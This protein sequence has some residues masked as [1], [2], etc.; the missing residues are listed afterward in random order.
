[1]ED[2]DGLPRS[3]GGLSFIRDSDNHKTEKPYKWTAALEASKEHL[4]TNISLETRDDIA[5]RDIRSLINSDKLS[6]RE[7][8]FQI[9][10]HPNMD[11]SVKQQDS[12][13]EEY[14]SGLVESIKEATSAEFACCVNFVFRQCTQAMIANPEKI[15]QMAGTS[16]SAKEPE[17]PAFPAHADYS[18]L[19]GCNVVNETLKEA[20]RAKYLTD[21]YTIWLLNTWS[22]LYKP[23][24]NAPL[25]FCHPASVSP[26]DVVEVDAVRPGRV[27]GVRYLKYKPEHQW[28]WCSNQCPNEVS[29]FKSWDSD[30]NHRL[31]FVP[32]GAVRFN[33]DVSE[34]IE[35]PNTVL[36]D[37]LETRMI[38]ILRN[39]PEE[40]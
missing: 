9:L 30:P 1:M 28:Y 16:G 23:V 27:T 26:S 15:S 32:H 11:Y 7:H 34:D 13:L 4:R 10:R 2:L 39:T 22:P 3:I 5:F 38:V 29:I 33:L 18:R 12:T 17:L 21:E 36:R 24:Q 6:V 35:T 25:A 40:G 14:V 8:G 20:E 19:Q 37:S 31:P